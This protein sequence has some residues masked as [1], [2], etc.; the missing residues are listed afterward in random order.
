MLLQN[1]RMK[2]TL[3]YLVI[4]T[5][6][7]VVTIFQDLLPTES[8]F[9]DFNSN[10]VFINTFWVLVLPIAMILDSVFDRGTLLSTIQPLLL[11]R[12]SYIMLA[13]LIHVFLF[14]FFVQLFSLPIVGQS[15]HFSTAI[16]FAISVNLYKYLLIYSIVALVLLKRNK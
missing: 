4:L 14:A 1:F 7:L 13:S 5:L 11:K 2:A 10:P 9:V 12:I 16:A 6:V 3:K 15:L 8:D